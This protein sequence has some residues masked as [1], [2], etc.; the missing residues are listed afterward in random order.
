VAVT[1][2]TAGACKEETSVSPEPAPGSTADG[3]GGVAS[4]P[5]CPSGEGPAMVL[6]PAPDGSKYC[7]DVRETTRAEYDAF[8]KARA[9]DTSGQPSACSWNTSFT[10]ALQTADADTQPGT[11]FFCRE[12]DWNS[13][14]PN[15]AVGCVDFCDALAYCEWAGKRLCG[16]VG[17]GSERIDNQSK[18][19]PQ[20][21]GTFVKTVAESPQSEFMNACTQQGKTTYPYGNTYQPGR[22]IDQTWVQQHGAGALDVTDTADRQ[23]RGTTG[24][25]DRVYDVSGSVAEWQNMCSVPGEGCVSSGTAWDQTLGCAESVGFPSMEQVAVGLGFRCCADPSR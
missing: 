17:K 3:A 5:E 23:C 4:G 6:L 21:W 25:F 7:M 16:R 11:P 18:L 14:R 19:T 10:P 1:L 15:Q 13:M 9:G 12:A 2:A 24:P 20:Q 22:C 8:V